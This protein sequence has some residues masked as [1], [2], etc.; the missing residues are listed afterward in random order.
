MATIGRRPR[1]GDSSVSDSTQP[2]VHRWLVSL[3]FE[4]P[5]ARE[6]LAGVQAHEL[7]S[8]SAFGTAGALDRLIQAVVL[9]DRATALH[10]EDGARRL[11][12]DLLRR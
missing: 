5:H 3:L 11:T 6:S 7:I 4:S 9:G 10:S 12:Y 1:R 2:N 8:S